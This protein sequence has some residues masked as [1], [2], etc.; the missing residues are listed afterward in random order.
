MK[1]LHLTDHLP[2]YHETWGGAEQVAYRY[3]KLLA[4]SNKINILVGS[5]KPLK[6]PKE[7]FK[8][9]RIR[10]IEDFF[11]KRWQI[12]ITGIKNRIISLISSALFIFLLFIC[13]KNRT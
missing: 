13:E 10:V 5:V 1:I 7:N 9:R 2:N 12:Y 11:P 8:F 4:D 6:E 3:I